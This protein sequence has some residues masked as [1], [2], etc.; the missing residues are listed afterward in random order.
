MLFALVPLVA[1][2]AGDLAALT[3]GVKTVASPGIPGT[4]AI[5]DDRGFPFLAGKEEGQWRPVAAG[6][7][8]ERG[9]MVVF[10]HDGYLS[11]GSAQSGDTGRLLRNAFV[12]AAGK[13]SPR[14]GYFPG[15]GHEAML[16]RIGLSGIQITANGLSGADVVVA[17]ANAPVAGV[18]EYVRKGGGLVVASTGWGWQQL[19]P[20]KNLADGLAMNGVLQQAGL[21]ITDGMAGGV[22]PVA[23]DAEAARLKAP[24]A[25]AKIVAGETADSGLALSAL[26]SVPPTHPIWNSARAAVAKAGTV[27]PTEARKIGRAEG[28]ARLALA[29]RQFERKGGEGPADPAAADYPGLPAAGAKRESVTVEVAADRDHWAGTGAY[30]AAGEEI[31]VEVPEALVGKNVQVQIGS[32]SD[33]LWHLEA[34]ARHPSIVIRKSVASRETRVR[35]PFGGLVY[36]AVPR[37]LGLPTQRVKVRNAVRAGRF[38][39]GTTSPADWQ[40]ALEAGAPWAEFESKSIIFTVPTAEARKV[41]DPEALMA[42]WER[43]LS[44]YKELDGRPLPKRAERI[45]ADR[46]ISAGYMHSGYPIMTWLDDSVPLSL[47]VERLTKEGTWG[48][49]HELGHNHQLEAWTFDGTGEVTCN[50]YSLYMM[51]KVAGRG[52]WTRIGD[53]REKAKAHRAAGAPFDRWK[54]DPFLALTM[55]AELIDAFGW[56]ACQRWLRDYDTGPRPRNDAERRDQ[57]LTRYS[58]V[59]NRNLG[60]F[61]QRWGVP[62][63]EAA[64]ASV[65]DLPA[66]KGPE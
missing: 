20:G 30:A 1:L 2:S 51:E 32:H 17:D 45:V 37:D 22:R 13:A 57:F 24:A 4:V 66:W 21:T 38:V 3:D 6:S 60:P 27:V 15:R 29:V 56:E 61:F 47:S 54:S 55:Y 5:L 16:A 39:H 18:T 34:W 35:S 23:D 41:K 19:N 40:A 46:Q 8:L 64:R 62:T 58:K 31:V 26:R 28:L 7:R 11:D 14:V 12:W 25:L 43:I 44:L 9:R 48:H 50:L 63:S 65:K 53:Q 42:L 36:L 49:W 33:E 52:I 59:V 10:G